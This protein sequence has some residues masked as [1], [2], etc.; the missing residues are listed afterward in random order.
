[1]NIYLALFSHLEEKFNKRKEPWNNTPFIWSKI[2]FSSSCVYHIWRGNTSAPALSNQFIYAPSIDS[3][4]NVVLSS[5]GSGRDN[6]PNIG[7]ALVLM[8]INWKNKHK[9]ILQ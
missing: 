3:F 8:N 7:F 2:S 9:N 4:I 6:I 1:M 5:I